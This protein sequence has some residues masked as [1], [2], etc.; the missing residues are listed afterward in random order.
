MRAVVA[1]SGD[2]GSGKST[3]SREVAKRLGFRRI[4]TG[5]VQRQI[6]EEL[7]MS[8]LEL[9]QH[10]ENRAEFDQRIDAALAAFADSPEPL[11]ADSRLAWFLLPNAFKVHLV[12]EPKVGAERVVARGSRTVESYASSEE[13]LAHIRDRRE[14]ERRRFRKWHG[15]DIARL[16]NYNLVLD[17][18]T[19]LVDM[20][21][22]EIIR[23]FRAGNWAEGDPTLLI[24]PTRIYPTQG[25]SSLAHAPA[26]SVADNVAL[27]GYDRS[28]SIVVGYSRPFFFAIDGHRRLSAALRSNL[29]VIPCLLGA[30]AGENVVGGMSASDYLAGESSLSWLYDWEDVHGFRF[31]SYPFETASASA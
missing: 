17:T 14:S 21:A 3:V 16:R 11:V 6:A 28:S 9:N 19:A 8:T 10:S 24:A 27:R 7:G 12:V 20:L 1:I 2:L 22:E 13:A 29:P 15:V 18:T 5:D 26:V 4:G 25:I 23:A 30:E 31:A